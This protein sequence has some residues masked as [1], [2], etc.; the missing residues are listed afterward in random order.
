M[1]NN[2]MT[3]I[4]FGRRHSA[5]AIFICSFALTAGYAV[6]QSG[7]TLT[8]SLP[9]NGNL[10]TVDAGSGPEWTHSLGL[11]SIY[12]ERARKEV[13]EKHFKSAALS[14]RKASVM[15]Q[16]R[17][18]RVSG[19]DRKRLAADATSLRLTARDVA[20]GAITTRA[21]LDSVLETTHTDLSA[22]PTAATVSPSNGLPPSRR[23]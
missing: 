14:L 6:A 17:S 7:T 11:P 20:A 23:D 12:I 4:R 2:A 8:G 22:H 9:T 10:P 16:Q 5:Y 19:L 18:S 15:L 1:I 21:Q 13:G 3:P